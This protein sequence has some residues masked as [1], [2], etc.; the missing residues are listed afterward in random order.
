MSSLLLLLLL[1]EQ[2]T[3]SADN[4]LILLPS[5]ANI[6][7]VAA[8]FDDDIGARHALTPLVN[9]FDMSSLASFL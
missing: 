9:V 1:P 5:I 2:A 8:T 3:S 6:A 4:E 7:G